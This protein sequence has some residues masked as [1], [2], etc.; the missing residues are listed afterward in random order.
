VRA[1]VEPQVA[2]A[3]GLLVG[4][5]GVEVVGAVDGREERDPVLA[6]LV[7]RREDRLA[8]A[9]ERGL[10]DEREVEGAAAA[11]I[12]ALTLAVDGRAVRLVRDLRRVLRERLEVRR[13]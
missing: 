9:D 8:V 6:G 4:D 13:A 5:P 10:V 12:V 2:P 11:R 3:F 7:E 1:P